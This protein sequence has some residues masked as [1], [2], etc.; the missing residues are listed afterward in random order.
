M[1]VVDLPEP[2]S[3]MI[4]TVSP[5][6]MPKRDAVDRADDAGRG[7]QFDLQVVDLQ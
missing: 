5:A 6:S 2:D 4:V 1:A 3:P 7:D